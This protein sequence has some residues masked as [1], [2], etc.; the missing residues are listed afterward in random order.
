MLTKIIRILLCLNYVNNEHFYLFNKV[1]QNNINIDHLY[2]R[3]G[4]IINDNINYIV[5]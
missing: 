1:N 4:N 5:R 2:H 3:K